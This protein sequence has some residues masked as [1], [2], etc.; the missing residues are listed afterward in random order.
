MGKYAVEA[1]IHDDG[2]IDAFMR[3]AEPGE[4]ARSEYLEK[5][6]LYIEIFNTEKEARKF[7]RQ[8]AMAYRRIKR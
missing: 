8:Y 4:T 2:R 7:L 6:D 3:E 5:Y 1:R